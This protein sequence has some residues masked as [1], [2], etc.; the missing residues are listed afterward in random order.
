MPSAVLSRA[1]A[2]ASASGRG[3]TASARPLECDFDRVQRLWDAQP[4]QSAARNW[5]RTRVRCSGRSV[6]SCQPALSLPPGQRAVRRSQSTMKS[7]ELNAS[8]ARP[9]QLRF[10]RLGPIQSMSCSVRALMRWSALTRGRVHQVFG[11]GKA[12]GGQGRMDRCRAGRLVHVGRRGVRMDHQARCSCIAGFREVD[13]GACPGRA[14]LGPEPGFGVVGC[15]HPV[16]GTAALHR[17]QPWATVLPVPVP[18]EVP[19]PHAAQRLDH[20]QRRGG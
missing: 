3:R 20:R 2:A 10:R 5:A 7:A 19:G 17:P 13:H 9:C 1:L 15:L 16:A 8:S 6:A 11:R 14:G 4:R 12:F 18:L